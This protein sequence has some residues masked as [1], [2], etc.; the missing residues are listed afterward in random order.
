MTRP[1]Q[2]VSALLVDLCT[3]VLFVVLSSCVVAVFFG[4]ERGPGFIRRNAWMFSRPTSLVE[5][6]GLAIGAGIAV[7]P[8]WAVLYLIQTEEEA[9]G[10]PGRVILG[11]EF[12]LALLWLAYL[13]R[14]YVRPLRH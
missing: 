9:F 8:Q 11:F 2:I 1:D 3:A 10:G 13:L 14:L 12:V 4:P 5:W 7:G 6:I